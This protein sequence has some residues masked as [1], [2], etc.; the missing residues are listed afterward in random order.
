MLILVARK[1][2]NAFTI[3]E[4]LVAMSLLVIMLGLSGMVFNT[5]V[6]AHRTAGASIDV[7][8]N[9]RAV[10]DQLNADFQGLRKDAP[11][12]IA[13]NW[14][15][16]DGDLV[17]DSHFDTIHFFADGDFQTTRQ[18]GYDNTGD[19]TPDGVKTIHGNISRIYYGH[20]NSPGNIDYIVNSVLARKSHILTADAQIFR[21]YGEIPAVTDGGVIDY[22]PFDVSFGILPLPDS[23]S[24]E[25]Q[26]EFNTITLT[27]WIA[28]LN[29]LEVVG[30]SLEHVNANHFIDVCMT[31]AFRPQVDLND[32][33]TLHLLLSQGVLEMQIQW[34]YEPTDLTGR[35]A[36]FDAG[37]R[38]WPSADPD[39]DGIFTDS[40]FA[41]MGFNQFGVDFEL[42]EGS[43]Y[44][45][46]FDVV[47]ADIA[48]RCK[49][50]NG[51]GTGVSFKD[52]FYPKA[53]K[54]TF[55]L[56]DSNGIFTDG[57][58]FTHIVTID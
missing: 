30:V 17:P 51:A 20:S 52:V 4:L 41:T 11:V 31:D 45:N 16:T 27:N 15:D 39:G 48:K 14:I 58:T 2:N 36:G 21:V 25:N 3:V 23:T 57:K 55:V 50:D 32:I 38:W 22:T 13:F 54:F 5:T 44:V 46:W 28:A 47:S 35:V 29:L 19:S 56:R 43:S 12:F 6:D 33:D 8:R 34:A 53:L 18:Y 24:Y 26:L 37:V 9:L 7:T 10:T 49:T 40:D 42:P 1:N